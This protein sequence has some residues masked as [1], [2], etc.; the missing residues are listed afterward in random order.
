MN[1]KFVTW[2]AEHFDW[3]GYTADEL[4]ELN[5]V[6]DEYRMPPLEVV[7]DL[8][9][10]LKLM[11]RYKGAL[12]LTKKGRALQNDPVGLFNLAAPVYL[13]VYQD[14]MPP[15]WQIGAPK[16]WR[17]FLNV[18]SIEA[19][20]GV[21]LARLLEAI[22]DLRSDQ[23]YDATYQDMRIAF[24]SSILRRLAWL[25]L[26]WEDRTG[27]RFLE[28]GALYKTPLWIAALKLESDSAPDHYLH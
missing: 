7:H 3:P 26:L 20:N 8:L 10:H 5:K 27:L 6:L 21:T 12:R 9:L 24:R 18:I 15:S 2:A 16:D 22:Y 19:R 23:K 14:D 13:Y 1:R 11:R 4:Y 28:E 25:G 17:I